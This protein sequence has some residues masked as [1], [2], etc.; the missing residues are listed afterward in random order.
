MRIQ[1]YKNKY[2]QTESKL[3]NLHQ[4]TVRLKDENSKLSYATKK[5]DEEVHKFKA[6]ISKLELSAKQHNY[7][8]LK[9]EK[10]MH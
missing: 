6:E 2:T 4:E 8:T 7:K 5:H 3:H 9:S 10:G 1:V